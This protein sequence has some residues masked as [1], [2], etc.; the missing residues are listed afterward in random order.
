MPIPLLLIKFNTTMKM[1]LLVL[2]YLIFQANLSFAQETNPTKLIEE[3]QV[4]IGGW[5]KLYALK[6]V[7]FEYDYHYPQQ[8]IRDFSIERYIFEGEHAWA[9]YT[10]HEVNVM[11]ETTD[12][13]I[14]ALVNNQ[15]AC[16]VNGELVE[17]AKVVGMADFLRRAN[18][19]WFTMNFKLNDPGTIHEYMGKETL[20]N[21]VYHKV[22]VTYDGGKTGKP[23]NDGYLLYINQDTKLVDLFYFSLPAMGMNEIGIKMEIDYVDMHGLKLPAK[24]YIYMP[25]KDGKLSPE[26]GLIQT[27][28]NITFN[29]GYKPADFKIQD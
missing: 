24:R 20:S 17:D 18:Y 25:D 26:P 28:S 6:D 15:A 27:S 12:E 13:V 10:T 19:F 22:K 5:D 7:T 16:S 2:S 11:P 14:Q 21:V 29:N 1:Q 9:K 4:A 8:D 3:M 23:Q